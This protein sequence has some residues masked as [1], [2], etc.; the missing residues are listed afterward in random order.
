VRRALGPYW[1][2]REAFRRR[3]G[4]V[5]SPC[6]GEIG[7][8]ELIAFRIY[9]G[10]DGDEDAEQRSVCERAWLGSRLLN[11]VCTILLRCKM[12]FSVWVGIWLKS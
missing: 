11:K 7:H 4:E 1:S 5:I 10:S 12:I 6:D 3:P 2:G 8:D 9:M